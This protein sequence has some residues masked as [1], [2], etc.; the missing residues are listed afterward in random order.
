M[1]IV[2]VL[3]VQIFRIY[4]RSSRCVGLLEKMKNNQEFQIEPLN[5]KTLPVVSRRFP[6]L[7]TKFS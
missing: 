2:M 1:V 5:K 7:V 3:A 6:S 4:V